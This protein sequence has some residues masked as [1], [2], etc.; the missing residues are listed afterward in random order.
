LPRAI[1]VRP[2]RASICAS[3][4]VEISILSMRLIILHEFRAG[5]GAAAGA[6]A[7]RVNADEC[8]PEQQNL[9]GVIDPKQYDDK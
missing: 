9:R 1:I 6:V 2:S 3:Q 5:A 4:K 7:V 8:C